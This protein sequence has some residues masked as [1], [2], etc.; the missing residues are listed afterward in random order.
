MP[1]DLDALHEGTGARHPQDHRYAGIHGAAEAATALEALLAERADEIAAVI[2]EPLVQGASG[3]R[4][5]HPEFLKRALPLKGL[6][7]AVNVSFEG[8]GAPSLAAGVEKDKGLVL[9]SGD[10]FS[11]D[12]AAK[13][14]VSQFTKQA[15]L[16][17]A[18]LEIRVN[19]IA[20]G[21]IATPLAAS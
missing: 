17:L 15:A 21:V 3:M 10:L 6:A 9:A 11:V 4:F 5:Y 20:P 19:A 16:E 12:L 2:L 13:A 7:T 1:G 8:A 14:A 18:P